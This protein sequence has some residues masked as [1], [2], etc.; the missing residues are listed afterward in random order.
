[1]LVLLLDLLGDD[2]LATSASVSA[3]GELDDDVGVL[4]RHQPLQVVLLR[5]ALHLVVGGKEAFLR[6]D[7]LGDSAV[8]LIDL[9][10][11]VS[12]VLVVDQGTEHAVVRLSILLQRR[13][14][15]KHK[16]LCVFGEHAQSGHACF[17]HGRIL[18]HIS[19]CALLYKLIK[20]I[21]VL[22]LFSKLLFP[23]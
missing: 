17:S 18:E 13:R 1:M 14:L 16:F 10:S 20:F 2:V 11:V 21:L 22:I 3:L 7:K 12:G 15:L 23:L 8:L 4:S 5:H 19:L 6:V 9:L